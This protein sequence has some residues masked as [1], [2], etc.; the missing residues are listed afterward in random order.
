VEEW[1]AELAAAA[2]KVESFNVPSYKL[3]GGET[4]EE[5][6]ALEEMRLLHE[7][8]EPPPILTTLEEKRELDAQAAAYDATLSPRNRSRKRR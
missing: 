7:E 8:E 2:P 5:W 1:N 6:Q 4:S 3:P